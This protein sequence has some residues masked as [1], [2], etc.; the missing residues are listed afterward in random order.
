MAQNISAIAPF[1]LRMPPAIRRL[2]KR[3]AKVNGRSMNSEINYQLGRI[4]GEAEA[5]TGERFGDTTP[6]AAENTAA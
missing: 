3:A 1:G 2:V 6:A 4:Y 5:A